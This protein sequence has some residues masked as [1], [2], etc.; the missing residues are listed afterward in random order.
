M[1]TFDFTALLTFLQSLFDAFVALFQ[2]FG[3]SFGE[4]E[5]PAEE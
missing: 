5:A 4:E 1:T 3:F 2:K